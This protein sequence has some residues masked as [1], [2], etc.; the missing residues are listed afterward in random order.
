MPTLTMTQTELNKLVS[1]HL[2]FT[3]NV[4][5]IKEKHVPLYDCFL[6]DEAVAAR[7][8]ITNKYP[9]LLNDGTITKRQF[10]Q[11]TKNASDRW[12]RG[13]ASYI[14]TETKVDRTTYL[15]LK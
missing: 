7:N 3:V 6:S 4:E 14:F 15:T 13:E 2:G 11:A 10:S 12:V 9:V 8:F 1:T 5:I